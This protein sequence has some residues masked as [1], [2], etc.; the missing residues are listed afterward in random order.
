[1][2]KTLPK[3]GRVASFESFAALIKRNRSY[4]RFDESSSVP[5]RALVR[6]VDLARLSPSGGNI[7]PL[8]FHLSHSRAVNELIFPCL[9]WA[10]YLR[11]WPGPAEGERPSAYI[12]ILGDKRIAQSFGV[13]HGIAAQSIMLG[14]A[15]MG[16]GGC[17]IG[18]INRERLSRALA[19]EPHF[20]ILLVLALGRPVEKVRL[21][22]AKGGDI[23]YWRDKAGTHFVPKRPLRDIIVS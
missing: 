15:A 4:R 3:S 19:L 2:K 14:A 21:T 7:Q 12:T 23:K 22:Q 13:N 5:R 9:A 16:L 6:L 18:S 10:G 1:M 8:K 11:D 17:M 20:E